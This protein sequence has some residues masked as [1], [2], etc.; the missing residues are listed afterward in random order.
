MNLKI[1]LLFVAVSM[2]ISGA[3]ADSFGTGSN[4]F[5]IDFVNIGHAGNVA[6]STGYGAVGYDY[7]MGTYEV[8]IDQFAKARA[9]DSR[10]GDGNENPYGI[11]VDATAA[12]TWL[13]AAK[14][15]NYLT[16][17]TYNGGAYQFTDAN[18]FT[19]VDRDAAV[20]AYGTV[21][22]LPTEDEW[23]KAAYLK[24]DGSDYTLY[25]SGNSIP[26]VET[27]ANYGGRSG[28][29]STPWD[30]GTGGASENNGTFDMN[31]NVW[32]W[33]ESAWDGNLN[34]PDEFRVMR[35]GSFDN[36]E[37][38]LRSSTRG[39]DWPTGGHGSVGFRV[40]AIPEPSSIAMIGLVSGSALF[41]R[42]RFMA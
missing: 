40:A 34:R 23:Y 37:N 19:G 25:A 4:P 39:A 26:G 38:T 10:I 28:A 2:V 29:Y 22:V 27:D 36:A 6:D 17:G 8:T 11:G 41:I 1:R 15:A 31:G 20:I 18:T 12:C 24:S 32:E 16:S 30:V 14:F 5:N 42:R 35:G 33:N 3:H 7:R 13:E 21:Y 9:A